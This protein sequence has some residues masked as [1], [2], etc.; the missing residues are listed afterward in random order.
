MNQP[1]SVLVV[2]DHPMLRSGLKTLLEGSERFRVVGEAGTA[3]AAVSLAA[4]HR[5]DLL[6]LDLSLPDQSGL[7]VIRDILAASPGT[8]IL[9]V[10]T[11]TQ[12][13]YVRAALAAGALG[14]V[15]KESAEDRL[16]IGLEA[17]KAGRRYLDEVVAA[18]VA[19]EL[20]GEGQRTALGAYA[21]LSRREQE[22]LRHVA[23]GLSSKEIG[24]R[25]HI[26][27]KT[28]ENHRASIMAKLGLRSA[29]DIVRFAARFGLVEFTD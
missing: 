6:T 4:E 22:I 2:D 7:A 8:A 26:S 13:E 12:P 29:V 20:S 15:A 19:A 3:A 11:H 16:L 23:H 5:P 1:H 18:G 28:V 10:S 9:V 24:E 17:I 14:Y 21:Q 27:P 25:L